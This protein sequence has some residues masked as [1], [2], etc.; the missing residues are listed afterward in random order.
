[1]MIATTS[2]LLLPYQFIHILSW[3]KD[4]RNWKWKKDEIL[5]IKERTIKRE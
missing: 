4:D 5:R 1:M 3:Y 2:V